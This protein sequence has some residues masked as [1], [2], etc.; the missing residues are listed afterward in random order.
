MQEEA[1]PMSQIKGGLNGLH[2]PCGYGNAA[3]GRHLD[4]GHG[5]K[6]ESVRAGTHSDGGAGGIPSATIHPPL[7]HTRLGE[8][9]RDSF[10]IEI[11]ARGVMVIARQVERL[12]LPKPN[13]LG[14]RR[15]KTSERR[16]FDKVRAE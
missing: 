13:R 14:S 11:R 6:F 16:I 10:D 3:R 7:R 15:E 5:L 8:I 2:F 1:Q 9:R 12:V 4:S